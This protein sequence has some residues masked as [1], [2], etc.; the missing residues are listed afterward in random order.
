MYYVVTSGHHIAHNSFTKKISCE[1]WKWYFFFAW[2][3]AVGIQEKFSKISGKKWTFE[4]SATFLQKIQKSVTKRRL[5][6]S[7]RHFSV[8]FWKIWNLS[9]YFQWLLEKIFEEVKNPTPA[10][11]RDIKRVKKRGK[12][13]SH[14]CQ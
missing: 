8:P 13:K 11:A 6:K 10:L 1:V 2:D 4:I 9:D 3:S 14:Q 5:L 7:Q 12:F